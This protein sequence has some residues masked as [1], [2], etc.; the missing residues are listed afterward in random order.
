MNYL[1][2]PC[3]VMNITQHHFEGNHLSHSMGKPWDYPID[4]GCSDSGR[5]WFYCPCDEMKVVRIYGVGASGTNTVWL[6]STDKVDMPIGRAIVTIMVEHAEDED[7]KGIKVGRSFKRG[8]KMFREGKDGG[9]SGNHFHIAVATGKIVG[10]GWRNN[11]NAWVLS[12]DG[13]QLKADKA[14][15]L[16]NVRVR[17]AA[18]YNFKNLPKEEEKVASVTEKL[19]NSADNYAA[20][21]V[22][23]AINK[24]VLKG[25][26]TGDYKLHSSVTRQDL[27]VFLDR[28]GLLD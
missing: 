18:G 27:F 9:A 1:T 14:F 25:T 2:Y 6:Q 15:Y 20:E 5:D 21:A 4:D 11:G 8:Q 13:E 23:K 28:L 16:D 17:N 24:G 12:T 7:L 22:K 19:D 3:K 10:N 26:T